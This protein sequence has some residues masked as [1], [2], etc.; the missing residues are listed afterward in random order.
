MILSA[1]AAYRHH[2]PKTGSY[3]EESPIRQLLSME[4][5]FDTGKDSGKNVTMKRQRWEARRKAN[6]KTVTI[7]MKEQNK[8]NKVNLNLAEKRQVEESNFLHLNQMLDRL[9]KRDDKVEIKLR[10]KAEKM[11]F[12][13]PRNTRKFVAHTGPIQQPRK[14]Y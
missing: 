7:T 5:M 14:H 9:S 13:T 1:F 12:A 11:S 4:E 2:E 10:R 8:E 6:L 3:S